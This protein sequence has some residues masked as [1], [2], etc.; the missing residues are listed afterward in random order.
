MD[1][2]RERLDCILLKDKGY[3]GDIVPKTTRIGIATL[4]AVLTLTAIVF[5]DKLKKL[6][7]GNKKDQEEDY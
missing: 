4:V 2:Q 5:H 6:V 7:F 3:T 1:R